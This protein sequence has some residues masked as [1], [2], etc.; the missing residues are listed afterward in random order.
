[1][2]IP[3]HLRERY[4]SWSWTLVHDC[5]HDG[6]TWRITHAHRR[7]CF[8]KIAAASAYPSLAGETARTRWA[9]AYLP[10]PE[11]VDAGTDGAIQ[12]QVTAALSGRPVTDA[13]LD[14]D[15]AHL[16]ELL[17]R[18]LRQFHAAPVATCPFDF[19]LETAMAH[20]RARV[21]ADVIDAAEDFNEDHQH[22]SVAAAHGA[23]ERL[24]P[25]R[26]DLVVCHGDYCP[27]NILVAD[28][29]VTGFV[30]LGELGV[31]DRWWDLA[32]GTWSVT[33][34]FGPGWEDLFLSTYGVEPD[35]RRRAFYRLL[36]DLAS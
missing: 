21:A 34:N 15:P 28:D 24:R 5:G 10:V 2:Q 26:E 11:M 1:V 8:V 23:L 25:D 20:V 29:T 12:W 13:Q 36:F 35:P 19:T 3:E 31:A 22:L 33:W 9:R 17:A 27:P 4:A 30:D 7:A 14:A 32:V 16:V 6:A 18:G